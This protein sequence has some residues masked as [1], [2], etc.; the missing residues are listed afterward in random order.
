LNVEII[1]LPGIADGNSHQEL[2]TVAA[3]MDLSA[4]ECC[5]FETMRPP[6]E[7][8]CSTSVDVAISPNMIRSSSI[9]IGDHI[10]GADKKFKDILH[11]GYLVNSIAVH[12]PKTSSILV[13]REV[14]SHP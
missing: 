4:K 1:S 2:S 9:R 5:I 12:Q 3:L 14:L 11:N 7:N 10:P 13:S 8:A 6:Q